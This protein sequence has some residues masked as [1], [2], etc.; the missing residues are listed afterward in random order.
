M[1]WP[2]LTLTIQHEHD[3]V[4]A[5]Q[6]ARQV[7]ELL[8]FDAQDQTRVATAVSEVARNA[9]EYAGG[10][11]V[12]FALESGG[13]TQALAVRVKDDG[14]GIAHLERVLAGQYQS[15]TG[16]GLGLVGARRLMD[17]CEI[18]SAP[19][20]GTEVRMKKAF[21]RR[22]PP[23]AA[24]RVAEVAEQLARQQPQSPFE[25]VQ[26]Q[27]R[28]LLRLLA[29][30]RQR[31]EEAERLNRELE[32]T[33]RGVV[34]LY[35]ELDDKAESLRRADE[36]KSRFLSHL[37][38]EFRT[39]LN[40]ILALSNLLLDRADGELTEEQEKQVTLIRKSAAGLS[41]MVNDLLDLAKIEAG[42]VDVHPAEFTAENLFSALRGVLRPLL[43]SPSVEL[44]FEDARALPPLFTD[45]GK[46]A[47]ILRN[48]ISNALKF[49]ER[50]EVRVSAKLAPDGPGGGAVTFAVADTGIG[51]APADQ[52]RIFDEFAQVENSLQRRAKGTG[53]GLP[54]S[55][56]LAMLLGGNVALV[57]EP[58]V[59]STFSV[60]LPVRYGATATAPDAAP[61]RTAPPN[62]ERRAPNAEPQ[63]PNAPPRLLLIED[64][65]SARYLIEKLLGRAP[66][67]IET[68]ADGL[69]GLNR[70]RES[71]PQV[72]L[73]DLNLPE[74]SGFE[75]LTRLKSDPATRHIPVVVATSEV[76]TDAEREQL[77]A[78]A[79]AI[80][81]KGSLSRETLL[82][83]LGAGEVE[84]READ[85]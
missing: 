66:Y 12:E 40:S 9:F 10:G 48:F 56:S 20:R 76:L 2:L 21:P 70:A 33:N 63:T 79:R 24:A 69:A 47:Q 8:G 22:A 45:E 43:T 5:R 61:A 73:L 32:D 67:L 55:R 80:L 57:S 37:S 23:V 65:D 74:L 28:E 25:E 3:V 46:L 19:G 85:E 60:T 34:A 17:E 16:L 64:D 31:Q 11:R 59:G 84:G 36:T 50:G 68:A 35:A 53:L 83:A 75:V 1:I 18:E 7:A 78:H 26:G 62:A 77:A 15:P 39:P 81:S 52:A 30:L 49:T 13:K 38:H 14:P 51:I 41:E 71:Q 29:E 82:S 44:V 6:R 54:L 27:N 58:G 42:K 4:A 72:I